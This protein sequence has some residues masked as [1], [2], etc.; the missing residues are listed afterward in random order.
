MVALGLVTLWT[1]VSRVV[2]RVTPDA[3]QMTT[4]GFRSRWTDRYPL[5]E[6]SSCALAIGG[7]SPSGHGWRS[8]ATEKQKFIGSQLKPWVTDEILEPIYANFP[9]LDPKLRE[10]TALKFR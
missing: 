6:I 2:I 3:L 4:S 1:A 5:N 9:S 10:V 8:L 7:F